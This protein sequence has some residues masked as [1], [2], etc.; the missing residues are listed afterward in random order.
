MGYY[1][2][3]WSRRRSLPEDTTV[4]IRETIHLTTVTSEA[5]STV[6]IFDV[7]R[8]CGEVEVRFNRPRRD[9]IWF[10][11]FGST[12]DVTRFAISR[13]QSGAGQDGRRPWSRL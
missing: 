11:R 4:M 9:L 7:N 5:G 1:N 8:I 12:S 3:A 2:G 13:A 6:K 10:G